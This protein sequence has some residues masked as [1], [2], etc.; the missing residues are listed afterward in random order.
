M[1]VL[2]HYIVR[3][4]V[5][6]GPGTV[7]CPFTTPSFCVD[8]GCYWIRWFLSFCANTGRPSIFL[9]CVRIDYLGPIRRL[10]HVIMDCTCGLS[11]RFGVLQTGQCSRPILLMVLS[12]QVGS[13]GLVG[14]PLVLCAADFSALGCFII[15]GLG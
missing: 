4:Q 9:F 3:T 1:H 12:R 5:A 11:P 13:P 2:L 7:G 10:F 15:C 6:L 14:R 8:T